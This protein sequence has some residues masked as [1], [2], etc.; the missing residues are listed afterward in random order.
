MP[1]IETCKVEVCLPLFLYLLLVSG[2]FFVIIPLDIFF[3]IVD[4]FKELPQF[5]IKSGPI[6]S[7]QYGAD[8][9]KR[10]QVIIAVKFGLRFWKVVPMHVLFLFCFVLF[11]STLFGHLIMMLSFSSFLFLQTGEGVASK[12]CAFEPFK[13]VRI[14][15]L[16][17]LLWNSLLLL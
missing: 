10:L 17:V 11:L 14:L 5:I 9:E 6:L 1:D 15:F 12:F 7:N 16:H 4:F 13:Q 2:E 3:S 8:W